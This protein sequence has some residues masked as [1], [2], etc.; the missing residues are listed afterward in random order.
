MMRARSVVPGS[1]LMAAQALAATAALACSP[2]Y[3]TPS[4]V[5]VQGPD[6]ALTI[7]LNETDTASLGAAVRLGQG[8]FLQPLSEGNGCYNSQHLLVHD[9]AQGRVMVIGVERF[10]MM[11]SLSGGPGRA[12]SGLDRIRDAAL[13]ARDAGRP[14]RMDRLTALSHAEGYGAPQM[15]RTSQSLRFGSHTMPLSCACRRGPG[16]GG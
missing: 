7:D 14:L 12:G 4:P 6:C 13:A 10:D 3:F 15:L 2:S 8:M 9:C 1:V 5:P 16:Q 11:A